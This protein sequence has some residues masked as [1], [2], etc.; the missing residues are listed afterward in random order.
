MPSWKLNWARSKGLS[1]PLLGEPPG[2]LSARALADLTAILRRSAREWGLATARRTRDRLLARVRAVA[3]GIAIGHARPDVPTRQPVLFLVE[4]PWVVAY[5]PAT[6]QVLRILHGARD[7]P[8]LFPS[9]DGSG[10]S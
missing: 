9:D 5:D 8:A 3:D 7:L 2:N 10:S 1:D 6:R 4:A